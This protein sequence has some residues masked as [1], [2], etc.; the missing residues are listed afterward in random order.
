M[1]ADAQVDMLNATVVNVNTGFLAVK[2]DERAKVLL[3]R[4]DTCPARIP[5][6]ERFIEGE[7]YPPVRDQG[8]FNKYVRP[9][10]ADGELVI[11]PCSEANGGI[12]MSPTDPEFCNG[13]YVSHY[14]FAKDD[15]RARMEA[16]FVVGAKRFFLDKMVQAGV[17]RMVV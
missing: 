17:V 16:E 1:A 5:G 4:W 6:C 7:G 14:W 2:S 13:T 15:A 10:M 3:R 12:F 9:L 11:V 8:A